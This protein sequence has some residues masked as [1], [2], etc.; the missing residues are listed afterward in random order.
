MFNIKNLSA[1][2]RAHYTGFSLGF[3]KQAVLSLTG[4]ELKKTA[5]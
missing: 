2:Q 5:K 3:V 4:D 1:P